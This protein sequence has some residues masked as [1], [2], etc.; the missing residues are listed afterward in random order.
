MTDRCRN[1]GSAICFGSSRLGLGLT[2]ARSKRRV[3]ESCAGVGLAPFRR[4]VGQPSGS[5]FN[6][7]HRKFA[8]GAPA[9][10]AKRWEGEREG[11]GLAPPRPPSCHPLARSSGAGSAKE[12]KEAQGRRTSA[13][14]LAV[15][16]TSAAGA[17][18]RFLR[19][20]LVGSRFL[21]LRLSVL[22]TSAG[23]PA[24][25]KTSAGGS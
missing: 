2:A 18:C 16:K 17:G 9:A 21:R 7:P 10:S 13:G 23:G 14:G 15:L 8:F 24:V 5:R 11:V 20:R 19:L 1:A 25:L 3:Q 4:Q 22:K 6:D 12:A